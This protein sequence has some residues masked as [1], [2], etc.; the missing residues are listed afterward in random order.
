MS[1]RNCRKTWPEWLAVSLSLFSLGYAVT[2]WLHPAPSIDTFF[3]LGASWSAA[4]IIFALFA[5]KSKKVVLISV[6]GL[7][8]VAWYIVQGFLFGLIGFVLGIFLSHLAGEKSENDTSEALPKNSLSKAQQEM[9]S[10]LRH[11]TEEHA[12]DLS[13]A[14]NLGSPKHRTT[15]YREFLE[16]VHLG[17]IK[18]KR[19]GH[20]PKHW[21]TDKGE[22]ALREIYNK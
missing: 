13:T 17:F 16:L 19:L 2:I 4:A 18:E 5:P 15:L 14:F 22:A 6:C 7:S 12:L 9:L 10:F 8:V 3:W 1:F 21:I 11:A 20:K